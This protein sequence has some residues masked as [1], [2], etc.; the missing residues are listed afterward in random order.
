MDVLVEIRQVVLAGP[1]LD[2]AR[3]AIVVAVIVVAVAVVLKLPLAFNAR[4]EGL[5][6]VPVAV[7]VAL[8]QAAAFL[9]QRYSVVGRAGYP[10]RLDQP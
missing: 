1:F 5:A 9:R 7:T 8:Q 2:L 10:S 3:V 4:V 6:A